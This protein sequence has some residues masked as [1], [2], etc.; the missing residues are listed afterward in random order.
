MKTVADCWPLAISQPNLAICQLT[1]FGVLQLKGEQARIFLNGQV[2][3]DITRLDAD[4]WRFGA[5][6]DPKGK[7]IASFRVFG[8]DDYLQLLMPKDTLAIDLPQ[9][10]KYA[11]FSKVELSDV[12]EQ[13]QILGVTGRDSDAF[14]TKHFGELPHSVNYLADGSTLLKC[15]YGYLLML[16]K[17]QSERITH[18]Q[19][20]QDSSLWQALEISAGIANIG[21]NHSAQFVPQMANIQAI[22]GISFTKGCYMGQET[23][24]R[25]KY[26]G[27][28]KRALYVVTGQLA[29]APTSDAELEMDMGESWRKVG[30]I[31]ESSFID[32]HFWCSAVLPNDTSMDSLLRLSTQTDVRLSLQALPYSLE[33]SV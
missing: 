13:W 30:S 6:C 33:E 8:R 24:A 19:S 5:H 26:R 21:A 29:Q 3:A 20:I 12:S 2:T 25:M 31:I 23:I 17:E 10:Q 15:D 14:I 9:M 16:T 4:T 32:G 7:M 22:D 27:G 18:E 11:V 28:N 1:H